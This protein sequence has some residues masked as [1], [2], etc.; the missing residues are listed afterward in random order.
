M[1]VRVPLCKA[2]LGGEEE[3]GPV[4]QDFNEEGQEH[5][6]KNNNERGR[7]AEG[8]RRQTLALQGPSS[9]DILGKRY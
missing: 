9:L 2:R 5:R 3:G 8:F 1:Y 7:E 6:K 4:G